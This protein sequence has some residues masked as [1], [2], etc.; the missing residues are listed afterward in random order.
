M[1]ITCEPPTFL[2]NQWL[3]STMVSFPSATCFSTVQVCSKENFRTAV[4]I[5]AS[6]LWRSEQFSNSVSSKGAWRDCH[7]IP[8]LLKRLF[9]CFG[10]SF[11]N[12]TIY[13]WGW[14]SKKGIL[15]TNRHSGMTHRV[16]EPCSIDG[17]ELI[18]SKDPWMDFKWANIMFKLLMHAVTDSSFT[19]PSIRSCLGH[20]LLTH[21]FR[22][23]DI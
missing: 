9:L 11:R 20:Y 3:V 15:L 5:T 17:N 1:S 16:F 23:H 12:P 2:R 4:K 6:L 8:C 10:S 7:L 19:N 22:R 21:K 18:E 13:N 14:K